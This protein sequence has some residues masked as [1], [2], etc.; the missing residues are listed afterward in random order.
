MPL[1]AVK[2]YVDNKRLSD[3]EA[4]IIVPMIVIKG[5]NFILIP[6]RDVEN[7]LFKYCRDKAAEELS[8]ELRALF[9]KCMKVWYGIQVAI[10]HPVVK[11]VFKSPKQV[12][13]DPE[14]D[15]EVHLQSGNRIYDQKYRYIKRIVVSPETVETSVF[16]NRREIHR[17]ATVWFVCGHWRTYQNGTKTFI[18]PYL[19]GKDRDKYVAIMN[20][21]D[22][23]V[24]V[25]DK[26]NKLLDKGSK[27]G[28]R[29]MVEKYT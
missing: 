29:E 8:E 20:E 16:G 24:S 15:R 7:E 9:Q 28:E 18:R 14:N 26:A 5:N 6:R 27:D 11:E 3:S 21:R 19:K 10:L 4:E 12:T 1:G 23:D 2:M 17:R 22:R 25:S 13:Y